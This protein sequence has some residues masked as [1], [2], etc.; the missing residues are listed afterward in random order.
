VSGGIVVGSRIRRGVFWSAT[1][2]FVLRAAQFGMGVVIARIVSPHDFGVFVVALTIYAVV[3][4]VSEVGVG[5]AVIREV[6]RSKQIAPTVASIALASS[7]LLAVLMVA[8]SPWLASALGSS[9]ATSSIQVL[10]LTVVLAGVGAV[11]AALMNREYMQKEQFYADVGL[12][13]SANGVLV[14]LALSGAGP[15]A[16]AWSRVA[17][18]LVSTCLLV[19]LA[20]ER[21]W[22]RFDPK[23]AKALLRF[24]LPLA[25][26]N[27]IYFAISNLDFIIVGRLKGALQLGYYN[28]AFNI[29]SW[30]V[31]VFSSVLNSVT[32][33][34]LARVRN[35]KSELRRHLMAGMSALS[36][37][38]FP[39]TAL[40]VALAHPLIQ[41]VYG[42]QWAPAA[43]ALIVLAL[44]GSV[45]L[46]MWLLSD[47]MVALG[48]TQTLFRLN[49]VWFVVLAPAI[50]FGVHRWGIV[51]A[52]LGQTAVAAVVILPSFLFVVRWKLECSVMDVLRAGGYPVMAALAAGVAARL[53]VDRIDS[54]W[55]ALM[56][57]AAIGLAVYAGLLIGWLRRLI[58]TLRS[59]YGTR[60]PGSV[61]PE[62]AGVLIAGHPAVPP[63]LSARTPSDVNPEVV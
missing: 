25:G 20:P 63:A 6:E 28:L 19:Y 30:P 4:N 32:L 40:C 18:Q 8:G 46:V 39:V 51:G 10:A 48:D 44:F 59:L 52:G 29:S 13:I 62:I 37:A 47:V 2:S 61:E 36:A 14:L 57:G 31:S 42:P 56:T 49:L 34:T 41:A 3:I 54:P 35:S 9:A 21:Y 17:G 22:P 5:A 16:L 38:A 33:P 11:P 43:N 23:E 26:G 12:F 53:V 27:L 60:Q 1:N 45:R 50:Y 24:G 58:A 15:L 55:P 7:A